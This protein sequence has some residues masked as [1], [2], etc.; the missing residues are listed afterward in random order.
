MLFSLL[1]LGVYVRSCEKLIRS[2][3]RSERGKWGRGRTVCL[4]TWV[5]YK[6]FLFFWR[7]IPDI[8]VSRNQLHPVAR[9]LVLGSL[10][11][12]QR[13][14]SSRLVLTVLSVVVSSLLLSQN[15][16]KTKNKIKQKKPRKTN[17][18]VYTD[19]LSLSVLRFR[20]EN[21]TYGRTYCL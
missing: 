10:S 11:H 2:V 5:S 4:L 20:T 12:Y 6:F 15:L 17:K 21:R 7:G 1:G 3:R 19:S 18:M 8:V 9:K 13:Q 14:S 16:Y